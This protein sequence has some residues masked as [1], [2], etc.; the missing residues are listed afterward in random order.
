MK[1]DLNLIIS[2]IAIVLSLISVILLLINNSKVKKY[3]RLYDKALSKFNSHENISD[4][5]ESIYERLNE[6]ERTNSDA[7]ER[8]NSFLNKTKTYI[9][10]AGFVKYNAYDETDNKL[11]FVIVLLSGEDDGILINHVYSKHGSNVY[12]KLVLNGKIE[13][14]ITEE[15]A[16]ALKIAIEDKGLNETKAYEMKKPSLKR[17]K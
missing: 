11:S 2:L 9:Q 4:E 17:R 16:E 8:I 13:E 10:K 6:I 1:F 14:R 3:K 7:L 15:E 5:F 12:S